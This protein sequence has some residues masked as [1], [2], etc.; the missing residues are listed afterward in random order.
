MGRWPI[1]SSRSQPLGPTA[2]SSDMAGTRT[3]AGLSA[4]AAA[5]LLMSACASETRPAEQA[6]LA[7]T[8]TAT[9]TAA[10]SITTNSVEPS[11]STSGPA[12]TDPGVVAISD[13]DAWTLRLPEGWVVVEDPVGVTADLDLPDDY[14]AAVELWGDR[15]TLAAISP[16]GENVFGVTIPAF[17]SRTDLDAAVATLRRGFDG[18]PVELF[19]VTAEFVEVEGADYGILGRIE[20][21]FIDDSEPIISLTLGTGLGD[22]HITISAT[23]VDGGEHEARELIA[24]VAR[25]S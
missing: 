9:S 11:T 21:R 22:E 16:S 24:S 6:A 19:E 23:V 7:S 14:L 4:F 1:S 12:A 8:T 3:R 25:R 2:E 17:P 5:A 10:Q 15:L 20:Y 18:A 13:D